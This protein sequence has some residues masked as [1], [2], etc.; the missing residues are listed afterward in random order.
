M[1]ISLITTQQPLLRITSSQPYNMNTNKRA[2]LFLYYLYIYIYIYIYNKSKI[3][4]GHITKKKDLDYEKK[5]K[6]V[7]T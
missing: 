7:I 4:Q 3:Q 2:Q 6:D 1:I 5:Q